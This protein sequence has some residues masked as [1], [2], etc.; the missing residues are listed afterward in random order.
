MGLRSGRAGDSVRS[1]SARRTRV[2]IRHIQKS[3]SWS[4]EVPDRICRYIPR[5][6]SAPHSQ[7]RVPEMQTTGSGSGHEKRPK[8]RSGFE[9]DISDLYPMRVLLVDDGGDTPGILEHLSDGIGAGRYIVTR[10]STIADGYGE[11]VNE[12]HDVYIVDH[13]IGARTG[14][15]LLARA[16]AEG[17]QLPIV[18]VAAEGDHR[19]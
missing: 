1:E 15:D 19:S 2:E 9:S 4:G 16:N 6:H 12:A 11:M 8:L 13:H 10:A 3:L 14:F 17:L 7:R 18:F 5:R